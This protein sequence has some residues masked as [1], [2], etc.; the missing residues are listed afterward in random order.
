[1]RRTR[2]QQVS[3]AGIAVRGHFAAD[4]EKLVDGD[5]L[6]LCLGIVS[7]EQ[8]REIGAALEQ[9]TSSEASKATLL[10]PTPSS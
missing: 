7:R 8:W 4:L 9:A 5:E 1:M 10:G 2:R 6:L 3:A